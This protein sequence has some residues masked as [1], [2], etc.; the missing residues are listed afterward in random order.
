M[1]SDLGVNHQVVSGARPQN[2]STDDILKA[3][4]PRRLKNNELVLPQ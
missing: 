1:F 2:P 4:H 3:I